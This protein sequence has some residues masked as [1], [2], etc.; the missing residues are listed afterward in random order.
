MKDRPK[1]GREQMRIS[2]EEE[3]EEKCFGSSW[4]KNNASALRV[5]TAEWYIYIYIYMDI[6]HHLFA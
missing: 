4:R 2:L 6:L 5:M 3:E 1:T